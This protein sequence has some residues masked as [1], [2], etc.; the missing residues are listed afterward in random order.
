MYDDFMEEVKET[1][2]L[3]FQKEKTIF[4]VFAIIED[5]KAIYISETNNLNEFKKEFS[6][7]DENILN[8]YKYKSIDEFKSEGYSVRFGYSKM[9]DKKPF[10]NGFVPVEEVKNPFE[11]EFSEK[12]KVQNNEI[13]MFPAKPEAV[14]REKTKKIIKRTLATIGTIAVLAGTAA[15][16]TKCV[17]DKETKETFPTKPS[18]SSTEMTTIPTETNAKITETEVVIPTDLIERIPDPRMDELKLQYE[19]GELSFDLS[20]PAVLAAKFQEFYKNFEGSTVSTTEALV[21]FLA[22]NDMRIEDY[23][24]TIVDQYINK[25]NMA[26][27][28]YEGVNPDFTQFIAS[29]TDADFINAM[30]KPMYDYK[31]SVIEGQSDEVIASKAIEYFATITYGIQTL[32]PI[33]PSAEKPEYVLYYN[34]LSPSQKAVLANLSAHSLNQP[35]NDKKPMFNIADIVPAIQLP[36]INKDNVTIQSIFEFYGGPH[37]IQPGEDQTTDT[38]L[39]EQGLSHREMESFSNEYLNTIYCSQDMVSNIV[40]V[41]KTLS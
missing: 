15:G 20:D 40:E 12:G 7:K 29:K 5:L 41:N 4:Y 2:F 24:F 36:G 35:A 37:N 30:A 11:S 10:D 26:I 28:Q 13:L 21:Y 34:Q 33:Y 9:Y 3:V 23:D 32:Q 17:K 1:K 38:E 27:S 19:A 6:I 31:N 16:I 25:V 8:S 39:G 22:A 14:K 18:E